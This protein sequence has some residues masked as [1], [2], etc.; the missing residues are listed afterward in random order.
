MLNCQCPSQR[1]AV[2]WA[3]HTTCVWWFATSSCLFLELIDIDEISN[4][5][6]CEDGPAM[7]PVVKLSHQIDWRFKPGSMDTCPFIYWLSKSIFIQTFFSH[8]IERHHLSVKDIIY[9]MIRKGSLLSYQWHSNNKKCYSY[10]LKYSEIQIHLLIKFRGLKICDFQK[11]WREQWISCSIFPLS[12]SS[13]HVIVSH[14]HCWMA[15][16]SNILFN[17]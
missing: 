8:F 17:R 6:N 3:H 10:R 12:F 13:P 5:L 15:E 4:R 16:F 7:G 2:W 1:A 11:E 9:L 14:P